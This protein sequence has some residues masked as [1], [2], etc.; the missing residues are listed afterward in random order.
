M[1]DSFPELRKALDWGKLTTL[2]LRAMAVAE[3]VFAGA[4]RSRR[5]G[6]GVE[7]GGHRVYVPGD[8]LRFL[9]RRAMMRHDRLLVREFETETNRRLSLLFDASRSMHYASEGARASKFG[10]GAVVLAA[11]T[12]VALSGSDTVSLDWIAGKNCRALPAIGGPEAFERL[13]DLLESAD[14]EGDAVRD[15]DAL[16]QSLALV[17]RRARRGSIVVVLSDFLDLPD[18]SPNRIA[19]LSSGGRVVVGVSV[20]DPAE[21]GFPFQGPIRFRAS[22]GARFVETDASAARADYLA[23]LAENRAAYRETLVAR[24]GRFVE[25]TSADDPVG[26][27]RSVLAAIEG[28]PA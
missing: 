3:G 28:V 17:S 20:L 19:A 6:A 23:A 9:D 13:V 18:G 7:F 8:D 15:P 25:T 10:F 4:H 27:V 24:G 14:A 16:E 1:T 11:L 5:K 26:V 21:V 22:E 2:R 12:R